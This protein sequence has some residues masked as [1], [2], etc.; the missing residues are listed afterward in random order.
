VRFSSLS[1]P[2]R[3]IDP[4]ARTITVTGARGGQGTST[5]AAALALFAAGRGPT[6]LVAADRRAMS[7]LLGVPDQGDERVVVTPTLTLAAATEAWI[8]PTLV[9]VIDAG[10]T[11]AG[12][13]EPEECERYVVVR[14]PCYLA[15][16]SVLAASGRTPDGVI[17]VAEEGRSLT[18][19]DVAE[20]TGLAVVA[21]VEAAPRVARSIDAGLLVARLPRLVPLDGGV[22]VTSR[23]E[24]DRVLRGEHSDEIAVSDPR[25]STPGHEPLSRALGGT[26]QVEDDATLELFSELARR[27]SR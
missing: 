24:R 17:L 14:G 15:L 7:T 22:L 10:T 26:E 5:V 1:L 20:V 8:E 27:W 12:P 18:A 19:R 21:T 25:R 2:R 9:R 4:V 23:V 11:T 16:A 3:M 13:P 6:T